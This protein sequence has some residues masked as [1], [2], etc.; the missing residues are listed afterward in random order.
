M[1]KYPNI[2]VKLI[3]E[4]G[5]AFVVLGKTTQEMRRHKVPKEEID[6]YMKEA[7]SGDYDNLIQVTGKWVNI[8]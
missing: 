1:P 6:A 5:N 3:G 8:L 7:T 2:K 4:N